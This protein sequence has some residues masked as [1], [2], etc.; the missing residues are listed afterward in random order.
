MQLAEKNAG[1]ES[2]FGGDET[3]CRWGAIQSQV[4]PGDICRG[5]GGK[6]GAV[7]IMGSAAVVGIGLTPPFYASEG[8]K[9]RGGNY[10]A[11]I[12]NN[13]FPSMAAI[14]AANSKLCGYAFAQ[15]WAPANGAPAVLKSIR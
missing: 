12:E 7:R 3:V 1:A 13:L 6:W 8:G 4:R 2:E 5:R 14:A 9:V 10:L 15:D 11:R